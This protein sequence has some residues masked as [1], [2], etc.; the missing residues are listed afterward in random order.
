MRLHPLV[1]RI[2]KA[3]TENVAY[4]ITAHP[5]HDQQQAQN[6]PR[7]RPRDSQLAVLH[8]AHSNTSG[9]GSYFRIAYAIQPSPIA[10]TVIPISSVRRLKRMGSQ[11]TADK[12]RIVAVIS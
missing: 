4:P 10:A 2:T 11:G 7:D 3:Y 5:Q 12:N 8:A 6:A 9:D 1:D